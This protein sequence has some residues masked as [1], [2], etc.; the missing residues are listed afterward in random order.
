MDGP[1][2]L[3]RLRSR[4]HK[5]GL[6][7]QLHLRRRDIL[8]LLSQIQQALQDNLTKTKVIKSLEQQGSRLLRGKVAPPGLQSFSACLYVRISHELDLPQVHVPI[9]FHH[10]ERPLP[11]FVLM[12]GTICFLSERASRSR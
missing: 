5:Y 10:A 6:W 7:F 2:Y 9:C 11:F 3:G 12:L 8:Q 1:L 4:Y